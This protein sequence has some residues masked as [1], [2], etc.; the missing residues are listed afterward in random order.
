[1][2]S[3]RAHGQLIDENGTVFGFFRE[4]PQKISRKCGFKN[5]YVVSKTIFIFENVNMVKSSR[6]R[7]VLLTPVGKMTTRV[8]VGRMAFVARVTVKYIKIND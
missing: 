6:I 3:R 8:R 4:N 5:D 7:D 2:P 1:V